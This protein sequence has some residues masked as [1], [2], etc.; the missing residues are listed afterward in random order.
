[1]GAYG[2]AVSHK[3]LWKKCIQTQ[4]PMIVLEDDVVVNQHFQDQVAEIQ[5]RLP[6]DWDLCLL[7]FNHD[8]GVACRDS[9]GDN[10][11]V[12]FQAKTTNEATYSQFQ[13]RTIDLALFKLNYACGLCAYMVSP[14]GARA[15]LANAT[16]LKTVQPFTWGIKTSPKI[17]SVHLDL[18]STLVYPELNSYI[19]LNPIAMSFHMDRNYKSFTSIGQ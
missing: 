8:A 3:Q 18:L 11:I 15:L 12:Y 1:M 14:K 16:P 9:T 19:T 17:R 6:A 7:A 13:E 4:Q 2:C 10:C 5:R